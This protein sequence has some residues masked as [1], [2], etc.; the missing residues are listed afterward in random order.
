MSEAMRRP[1]VQM[2]T[3][4]RR[5]TQPQPP[6]CQLPP[7]VLADPIGDDQRHHPVRGL[8][9]PACRGRRH[10]REVP[11]LDGDG[12]PVHHQPSFL[13]SHLQPGPLQGRDYLVEGGLIW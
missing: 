6:R 10:H 11:H 7:G 2:R 1:C 5:S 12:H 8:L 3:W 9:K 13:V 4:P